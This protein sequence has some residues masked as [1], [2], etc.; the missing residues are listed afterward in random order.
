MSPMIARDPHSR[1][2][3]YSID[4]PI[5]PCGPRD[6]HRCQSSYP[7][8]RQQEG[9]SVR[10]NGPSLLRS[11]PSKTPTVTSTSLART[12]SHDHTRPQG[13]KKYNLPAKIRLCYPRT[14]GG[15]VYRVI[16]PNL[17]LQ[18][19]ARPWASCHLQG[20]IRLKGPSFTSLYGKCVPCVQPCH[21]PQ[22]HAPVP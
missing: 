22:P 20:L 18:R 19:R 17:S 2:L 21:V 8:Y 1:F 9:G 13:D 3:F 12:W 7:C 10:G 6:L 5:P 16:E 4:L 14:R 15:W 11:I